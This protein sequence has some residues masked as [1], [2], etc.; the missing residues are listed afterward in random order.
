MSSTIRPA[1]TIDARLRPDYSRIQV[2]VLAIYQRELPFDELAATYAITEETQRA[3]LLQEYGATRAMHE[4]WQRD[5]R[6]AIPTARIVEFPGASLYMRV[7]RKSPCGEM[8]L[9]SPR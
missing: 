2:P 6:D 5:L 8:S 3:A 9:Y 4:S 7:R 1:I